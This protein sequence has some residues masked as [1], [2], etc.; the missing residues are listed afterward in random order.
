MSPVH[1][2]GKALA[3]QLRELYSIFTEAQSKLKAANGSQ[4]ASVHACMHACDLM[5]HRPI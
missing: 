4:A 3:K 2:E 1:Y 5:I